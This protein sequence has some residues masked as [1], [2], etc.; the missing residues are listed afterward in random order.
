MQAAPMQASNDGP[1]GERVK[2]FAD[3]MTRTSGDMGA[4]NM[5]FDAMQ[6]CKNGFA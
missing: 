6:Q 1:C 5:Y 3:C 4:C 2:A